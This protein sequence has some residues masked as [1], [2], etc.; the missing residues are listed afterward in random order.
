M[1]AKRNCRKGCVMFVVHISS[2]KG[3]DVEDVKN[4]KK[5]PVLQQFLDVFRI[6][7]PNFHPHRE[8]EFSIELVPIA[9]PTSKEP[10][11][12]STPELVE[13]KLQL[14]EILDKGYIRPSVSPWGVP[15]L[16][17]KKK[18]GT[19]RLCIDY[20]HLNKV[21]IKNMYLLSRIDEMFDHLNGATMF[22]KIDLRLGYHQVSIKEED[23]YKTTFRTRYGHYEFVVVPFGLTMLQLVLCA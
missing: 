22:S 7:I 11:N 3:K 10:Y 20:K 17:V 2:D 19:L 18:D 16:F 12:M 8:V 23:I 5:Y 9:A 14:K 1:Q 21:T 15:I 13:L 6:E 4:F